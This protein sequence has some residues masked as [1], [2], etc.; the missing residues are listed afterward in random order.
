MTAEKALLKFIQGMLTH[1]ERER[2]VL[3][4]GCGAKQEHAKLMREHQIQVTTNDLNEGADIVGPFQFADFS[5]N[6]FD[7]IWCAHCLEHQPDPGCFL[8]KIWEL[9]TP[10]G[11]LAITVPPAKPSI[12]GGHLTIWNLGLLYYNLIFSGF[13]C[14][15]A[16]HCKDGY[17]LSIIV[18]KKAFIMPQLVYDKGDIELLA[19]YFPFKAV[20]GFNGERLANTF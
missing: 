2:R 5:N 1:P 17:N 11:L 6:K 18:R 8:R 12:V 7:G 10:D 14:R 15:R 3:D 4:I 19:P 16:N 13:D 9:L 20:H